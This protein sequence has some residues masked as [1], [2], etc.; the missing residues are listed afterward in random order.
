MAGGAEMK[1][2]N[3]KQRE[4]AIKSISLDRSKC[5]KKNEHEVSEMIQMKETER[6]INK[7]EFL[8]TFGDTR[9]FSRI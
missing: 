7:I 9:K 6:E 2:Q 8:T 1:K 3:S 5:K 4:Y